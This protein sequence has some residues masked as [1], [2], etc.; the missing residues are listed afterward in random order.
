MHLIKY[1]SE[2]VC[3]FYPYSY[4]CDF[5][6]F[7]FLGQWAVRGAVVISMVGLASWVSMGS[8]GSPSNATSFG[9]A[10]SPNCLR[11]F[12]ALAHPGGC[13]KNLSDQVLV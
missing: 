11:H 4:G 8:E 5:N 12:S 13:R 9:T 2:F 10:L 6:G 3:K 7:G 1:L